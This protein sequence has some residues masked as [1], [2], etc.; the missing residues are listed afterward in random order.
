MVLDGGAHC[1]SQASMDTVLECVHAAPSPSALLLQAWERYLQHEAFAP[2]RSGGS[3]R[4]SQAAQLAQ[5]ISTV[6]RVAV[7]SQGFMHRAAVPIAAW[8]AP[9][10][11]QAAMRQAVDPRALLEAGVLGMRHCVQRYGRVLRTHFR[12]REERVRVVV[13][14]A[15]AQAQLGAALLRRVWGGR[16]HTP[17]ECRERNVSEAIEWLRRAL[18]TIS[19]HRA[20]AGDLVWA[21]VCLKL[22]VGYAA[23]ASAG[24]PDES[25]IRR[26]FHEM[27][28]DGSATLDAGEVSELARRLGAPMSK[29]G[30]RRAM[31]KMDFDS[32]GEVD[33]DEFISWWRAERT[34]KLGRL[35]NA[36]WSNEA[37]ASFQNALSVFGRDVGRREKTPPRLVYPLQFARVMMEMADVHAMVARQKAVDTVASITRPNSEDGV[38][39]SL[40]QEEA[41]RA[42][43]FYREC[44]RVCTRERYP[45]QWSRC[46]FSIG[47]LLVMRGSSSSNGRAVGCFEN[48]LK[49]LDRKTHEAA[50]L[51]ARQS[52]ATVLREKWA[53]L[54]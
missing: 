47:K 16:G 1:V 21:Q 19:E 15:E 40:H 13:V 30:L 2:G 24:A 11:Q 49:T 46:E 18:A 48:V 10:S 45:A 33:E 36:R 42:V 39:V 22:G 6:D 37:L 26:L 9:P 44:Q 35:I 8:N 34:S 29:A 41:Q 14:Q 20:V 12:R 51:D 7:A 32:S 31:E 50:W 5:A 28:T 17:G 52:L 4:L 54:S 43:H 25:Q 53:R 38:K 27:D 3:K 23:R